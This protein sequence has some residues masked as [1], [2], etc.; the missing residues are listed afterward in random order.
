MA[1]KFDPRPERRIPTLTRSAIMGG[2]PGRAG[3]PGFGRALD[4]AAF[5]AARDLAD[6][7]DALAGCAQVALDRCR[8]VWADDYGHADA[9]VEGARHFLRLDIPLRLQESHQPRLRP[10]VGIDRGVKTVGKNTGKVF[11]QP[12]PG[13]VRQGGD[14]AAADQRQQ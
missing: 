8:V 10:G 14:A 4:G 13:D 5:L 12:A 11:Q 3:A 7:V 1:W 2:A 6:A 9:A